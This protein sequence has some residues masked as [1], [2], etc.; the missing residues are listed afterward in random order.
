MVFLEQT[1]SFNCSTATS[2]QLSARLFD[3]CSL[4]TEKVFLLSGM[5]CKK[6]GLAG[7][8]APRPQEIVSFAANAKTSR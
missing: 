8:I 6:G 3:N 2:E 5:K 7:D 4:I 1:F